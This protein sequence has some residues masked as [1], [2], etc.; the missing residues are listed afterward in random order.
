MSKRPFDATRANSDTVLPWRP[1][2]STALDDSD[3]CLLGHMLWH[4][5]CLG[6]WLLGFCLKSMRGHLFHHLL[7]LGTDVSQART[8]DRHLPGG[9]EDPGDVARDLIKAYRRAAPATA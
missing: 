7:S 6:T 8:A 2:A 1:T 4:S 9:I 3:D 5:A